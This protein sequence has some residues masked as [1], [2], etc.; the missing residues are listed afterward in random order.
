M[1][2]KG[3][4]SVMA[5]IPLGPQK[6]ITLLKIPGAILILG[7]SKE[8]ISL[9]AEIRDEERIRELEAYYTRDKGFFSILKKTEVKE[10]PL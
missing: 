5:N 8:N 7:L 10:G 3:P 1:L 9:L 6:S 2:Q 4:M